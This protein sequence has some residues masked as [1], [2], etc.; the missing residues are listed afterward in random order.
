MKITSKDSANEERQWRE[1]AIAWGTIPASRLRLPLPLGGSSDRLATWN[2]PRG[3]TGLDAPGAIMV[4]PLEDDGLE[5]VPAPGSIEAWEEPEEEK[6]EA[7]P[8]EDPTGRYLKEIGKAKLLTGAQEVEIGKRIEAG[9][10]E[11][12]RQLAGVPL[13]LRAVT[14]LAAQVRA[15]TIPLDDL[16]VFP[17][18]EPTPAK[19]RAVMT[20]LGRLTR[21]A[22]T[23]GARRRGVSVARKRLE[24]AVVGLSLKPAVL[25]A[26]VLDLERIGRDVDA[27]EAG[28][29]TSHTTR[30]FRA[31]EARI[32]LPRAEFHARLS[33]IRL[34]DWLV[35][36]VKRRMIEANLRLVVSVAKRYR[37]SGVP[38]LDLIQE[39]NIGLIKAVDRFQYRRGFKFS[40]YATWWIRQSITRGIADRARTIR[41][42]VHL[43]ETLNRLAR[44]RRAL[45]DTLGREPTPE[46]L[47]QRMRIP[48][49]RIRQLLEAPG[50]TVS[51]QTPVGDENGAELGDFLAD[52][53]VAPADTDAVRHDLAVQVERAL[54]VLSDKEREVLRLRFGIGNEREHTLEEIG[55][56]FSLTRERIRQIE[57]GALRKLQRLGGGDGL[58]TLIGAG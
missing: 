56:R 42:P 10:A 28:P 32:G 33:A 2:D 16:V 14:D 36:E 39:G 50:R 19:V 20:V 40:T 49:S 7:I 46:E 25:E 30:E 54:G 29:R 38:F 53:Q 57:T 15:R 12:R 18:G 51:L 22:Q 1:R 52:T 41:I 5:A 27:L 43:V 8:A 17:E 44:V 6:P 11:L 3:A 35:R 23:P 21:L 55:E 9:Q 58:R 26:L 37:R 47:A 31:L 45:S 13:A 48:A 4:A 24:D 34:Q